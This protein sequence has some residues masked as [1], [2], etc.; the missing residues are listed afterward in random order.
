MSSLDYA[1]RWAEQ[2]SR[3]VS[4]RQ[5]CD[6]RVIEAAPLPEEDA[7]A[8]IMTH[9]YSGSY[10][11]ARCR[12]GIYE[13]GKLVGVCVFGIPA[14][15]TV[16]ETWTGFGQDE[17]VELSRFVLLDSV[18]YNAESHALKLA[19]RVLLEHLPELRALVSFSDPVPRYTLTGACVLPGHQGTIYQA[20]NGAYLGRTTPRTLYLDAEGRVI[21]ARAMQKVAQQQRGHEYAERL[22]VEAGAPPRRAGECPKAWLARAKRCL[23]KIRHTG[24]HGYVWGLKRGVS[25]ASKAAYPKQV[26]PVQ[27][28]LVGVSR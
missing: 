5:L 20:T 3:W 24:N 10:P 21:S 15:P 22:I 28:G 2:E 19:R 16:L 6:T 8:F 13:R 23:R 12:V 4:H 1:Q 7:K 27:L 14:G 18:G 11:A 26:D 9:H 25:F 17:A